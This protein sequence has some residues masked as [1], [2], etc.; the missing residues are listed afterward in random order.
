MRY[1]CL[2]L[3]ILNSVLWTSSSAADALIV[4]DGQP[5]A[6]IVIAGDP[7]RTVRLAAAELQA[8]LEKISGARLP[9]VQDPGER[10]P[11]KIFVGQS[12]HTD[13]LQ[14]S[15]DGLKH[16]AY[17]IVSGEDWLVLIGHDTDFVPIDPWP[18][19]NAD[20]VSG[21]VHAQWDEI[22]GA[23]W[24]NPLAGFYKHYTGRASDFGK[25]P[26]E[27]FDKSGAIHV[28]DF[29]ERGSFNAVCGFLRS[30]GVR[31]YMP[32]D[33]GEVVPSLATIPLPA[34]D[35]TVVPDFAVRRFNIR[36]GVHGRDTAMW[37]MRLGMRDPY[38]LEIPHGMHTMTHRQE[39][40]ETHPEWFALY[41]GKRHNQPG[42][43]L[44]QLCYSNDEL[45]QET[46]RY[47]RAVMDHYRFDAVSVM[48]PDGYV[49]ICQ[50]P[51]CEGKDTPERDSRGR[52]S[53][54]VW[55]FVNRVA[56][57]V[58][59][60]HP[61]KLVA[62]CAYGT[63]TL[64]PEKIDRLEPNVLVC[65]VGGRRP[66][67]DRPDEQDEIRRLREGWVAKTSN[68]IM[69]FEN[70]PF[71]DRGWYLPSF[72]PQVTGA[73]INA[74]KGIS[75]G[76]DIWLSV[77]QDFHETAIGFNHFLVYFTARMYW[78]GPE[79]SVDDLFHEYC[80]L[81]YG[82]AEQEM[83]AFFE[84]C[85]ANWREMANDK[86]RVDRTFDLLLAAQQAVEADSVYGRR[87]A[88]IA[89]YL[90]PLKN[91]GRQL[92]Q[93]RGPVPQLRLARDAEGIVIDGRLDDPFWQD[94][95]V[96][97]VGQL[98]ELQT[99]RRP[100]F[101]TTFKAAW[102]KDGNLYFAIRCD[103]RKGEP[104]NIGTARNGDQAIWYGDAVEI[105]LETESHSYYQIAVNPAGAVI[106]LD[107][108][109]SK[110][111]WYGWDSQAEV[112]TQIADDHWTV[113]IRIPV[114]TDANDPLH[115][116]IGRRPTSSL[117]WHFNICRQRLRDNGAEHSAFSPTGTSNF[118]QPLKFAHLYDGQSHQ[119]SADTSQ[120]DY[121]AASR[122]AASLASEGRHAEALAAWTE[123]AAGKLTDLQKSDALD[124]AAA[125][126]RSLQ[127]FA[128]A[129]ELA[130][131][132]PLTAVADTVRMKNLLAMQ[133]PRDLIDRYRDE[134]FDC[135]PFWQAGEAFF[136]RGRAWASTG[137]G[138]QAEADLVRALELITDPRSRLNVWLALGGN[139]EKNLHDDAAALEAYRLIASADRNTGSATYFRGVEGAAR[140]LRK[141]GKH[142]DA[143][144]VLQIVD[145]GK[146]RGYWRGSMQLALGETLNAAGRRAEA[147]AAYRQLLADDSVIPQHRQAAEAVV[148]A[149]GE[150]R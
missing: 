134:D 99:G 78:G 93:Q 23:R 127:D 119:F 106:D 44:N 35:E 49:A 141:A 136:A 139:R 72:V 13:R 70:Y 135:W 110:N 143:L 61:D 96:H 73:G 18:R 90:E 150:D 11:V 83:R 54:Y 129:A 84:Y 24:G 40:L 95:P 138:Q 105:L 15:A 67:S 116:V 103:D 117:P 121:L 55:D 122:A 25:P 128:R 39:I 14:V 28:W 1:V 68:P 76:E 108:G 145:L 56:R 66:T 47:V 17:R 50:C 98:R 52:L 71:T 37:A 111:S 29:D 112:A 100:V 65:I 87:V 142:D 3:P 114:V 97:A 31:W 107:R 59:K 88:L 137:S 41:G 86:T 21:R 118:H 75:Q 148:R 16:G 140:M 63:Y 62:N 4:Y 42:Q 32:G 104:L 48:P 5:R 77:G 19:N 20:W 80:R 133:K 147:L 120:T 9:I 7:P 113:E 126:A 82:P 69:V 149:I 115:Q 57:E 92:A 64:P 94:A 51:R 12:P 124:Q 89:A 123:L 60:T 33:L 36:F 43:R 144:A 146:L 8:Y 46:V 30:L 91:K 85:E 34:V 2:L 6:E 101:C 131:R 130:D 81:F 27:Q 58:R 45:F 26:A 10:T 22:T 109:A 125:S 74:T 79:Q 53:D 38:G 102:G 132:I